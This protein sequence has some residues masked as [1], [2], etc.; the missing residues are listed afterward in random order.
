MEIGVAVSLFFSTKITVLEQDFTIEDLDKVLN[1]ANLSSAP[2]IDG[3]PMK[4]IKTFWPL[5]RHAMIKAFN[6]FGSKG[7]LHGLL[8]IAKIKLIPKAGKSNPTS[9][10]VF[11]TVGLL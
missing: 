4:A 9:I 2:G 11:R 8:K 1:S 10:K 6:Y 7:E 3:F 5:L